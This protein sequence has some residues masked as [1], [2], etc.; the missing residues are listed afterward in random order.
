MSDMAERNRQHLDEMTCLLYVERQLDRTRGLEVSAHAQDCESCRMLLRTLERESRLLTRAMLE[1]DDEPLPAR[2]AAFRQQARK[3]MQW[4]WGVV[5]TLAATGVYALYTGYVEPWQQQLEQAGFGGTNLLGLLIFQGAIWKGWQSMITSLE[6][7][8]LL[9]L[10]VLCAAVFRRRFRRGSA[11][12]LMLASFCTV[13][14][15]APVGGA[16]E[17]RKG[18]SVEIRK[19]ETIK[20]DAY[21][22][23]QR[24][25]ITGTV[26]GDAFVTGEDIDIDGHV[27]G[28]VITAGKMLRVN[29]VVDGNVRSAGNTILVNGTVGKNITW[30][31]DTVNI[32]SA[33]KVGGSVTMFGG[34]LTIDGHLGRDAMFFGGKINI[35]GDVEGE[36]RA[37]GGSMNIGS[38]AKVGGAVHFRGENEAYI[39]SGAKLE[40][41]VDFTKLEHKRS[42]RTASYYVWQIIWIAAF[43]LFGMVLILLMPKYS[44]ES[45]HYVENYGA[46][47]G[48]GLLVFV[49]MPVAA[50]L[51]CLTVVGLF[52][53][54]S[55]LFIWYGALYFAQVVVG[56]MVGQ[57]ILGRT[58]ETWPLIGRMAL[59]V[60]V[61][62]IGTTIPEI[63]GWI[64]L[65]LM[66]WGLGALSLA[67]YR[68]FQ[69]AMT[70]GGPITP[71]APTLPP[72]T[73]G[74]PQMV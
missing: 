74:T 39:A 69:P 16:S 15:L 23:A 58:Q 67:V 49:A 3:S 52:L 54:I 71:V 73:M 34:T 61:V 28:D 56:A 50:A 18:Q 46:S 35:N 5:F 37:R 7:V 36:V 70:P 41:P 33:G 42:Y 2:L 66:F 72:G 30:F 68:R 65:G 19:D 60:A 1:E 24:V 32:D 29:G 43:V 53:G 9:T 47:F 45:V 59:G 22:S 12:A 25:R 6:V 57:W 10:A 20:G 40:S 38:T 64:K 21:L 11:L 8:A 55:A 26:D 13:L 14:A 31:G 4:I 63:G 48:L 62:R 51:A 44:Q 27:T 17:T